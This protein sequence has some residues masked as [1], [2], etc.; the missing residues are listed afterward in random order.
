RG[1]TITVDWQE[2]TSATLHGLTSMDEVS[3]TYN[4]IALTL[5]WPIATGVI[6]GSCRYLVKDRLDVTGARWSLPGGEA[7]LLLRTV[8]AN[9]DFTEYWQHHM[10]CEYQRTHTTLYQ[11]QLDIAA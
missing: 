10:R 6:E 7:V 1:P 2:L 5:G 3:G 8:I 9:G 11:E 4:H